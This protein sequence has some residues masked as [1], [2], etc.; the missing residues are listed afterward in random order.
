M[1]REGMWH[2]TERGQSP[3][4]EKSHRIYREP[5]AIQGC[6]SSAHHNSK[7]MP[8]RSRQGLIGSANDM[9]FILSAGIS[10]GRKEQLSLPEKLLLLQCREW[11]RG[12]QIGA[13]RPVRRLL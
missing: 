9:D 5:T 3:R 6:W 8:P 10:L 2:S 1:Q 13:E 4:G 12:R 7:E 11:I